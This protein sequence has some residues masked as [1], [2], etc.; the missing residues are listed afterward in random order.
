MINSEK[1]LKDLNL[2]LAHF[3]DPDMASERSLLPNSSP[4]SDARRLY[5]EM[6]A[7]LVFKI[8]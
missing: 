6:A 3:G 4:S 2:K 8:E 5:L 1:L 7:K